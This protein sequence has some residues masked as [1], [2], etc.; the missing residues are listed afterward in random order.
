MR[1]LRLREGGLL[2]LMYPCLFAC[3]TAN[4]NVVVQATRMVRLFTAKNGRVHIRSGVINILRRTS[5]WP[6]MEICDIERLR[7]DE[8]W[9]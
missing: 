4:R 2:L 1:L 3:M 6:S 5:C 9:K 8:R 7:H